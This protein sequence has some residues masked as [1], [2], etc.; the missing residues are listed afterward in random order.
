MHLPLSVV[1]IFGG[2]GNG[3][4]SAK[5]ACKRIYVAGWLAAFQRHTNTLTCLVVAHTDSR[6]C[7]GEVPKIAFEELL[8]V[9]LDVLANIEVA[10]PLGI[11]LLGR[12]LQCV[13]VAL[14][15]SVVT[16]DSGLHALKFHHE[17]IEIAALDEIAL[18]GVGI[19]FGAIM[20]VPFSRPRNI[21]QLRSLVA[22]QLFDCQLRRTAY[23]IR[24]V[25]KLVEW[26]INLL[27]DRLRQ[28]LMR[29]RDR[30]G[31][32]AKGLESNPNWTVSVDA[33]H[34]IAA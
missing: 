33:P 3:R 19:H 2:D 34:L 1:Y 20:L 11:P 12:V 32:C 22:V 26:L 7:I 25:N 9:L 18:G 15:V 27:A 17:L 8:T 13:Y 23:T 5:L 6:D 30:V 24:T 28:L 31:L 16:A 21:L 4:A 29:A 10:L 14:I